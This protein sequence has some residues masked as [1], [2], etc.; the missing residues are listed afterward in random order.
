MKQ[1]ECAIVS[2]DSCLN[3]IRLLL[4]A[5]ASAPAK[6]GKVGGQARFWDEYVLRMPGAGGVPCCRR[7]VLRRRYDSLAVGLVDNGHHL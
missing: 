2:G 6:E 4:Q 7:T 1:A 3:E 5:D